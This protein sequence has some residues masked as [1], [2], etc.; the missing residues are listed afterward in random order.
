MTMDTLTTGELAEFL[1]SLPRQVSERE[2]DRRT[3]MHD[4]D[5][6]PPADRLPIW[7]SK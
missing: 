4:L 1:H 7:E 6:C 5:D 3:A 2:V